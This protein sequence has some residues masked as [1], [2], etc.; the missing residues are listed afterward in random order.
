MRKILYLILLTLVST[1][2]IH[3]QETET[4]PQQQKEGVK[5]DAGDIFL[6]I[7]SGIDY[8]INA[9]RTS[10]D[11]NGFTF[12]KRNPHF[13]IGGYLGVM[14]TPKFRPRL[15]MKY[16]RTSYEQNWDQSQYPDF[17]K[18]TVKLGNLDLN[19]HF[20]YL[21]YNTEKW[22]VFIS[23]ALKCEFMSGE[24]YNTTKSNGDDDSNDKFKTLEERYP[25]SIAGG[26]LS[27]IFK[28]DINK[29][30]GLTFTPDYTYFFRK[31]QRVNSGAYQRLSFNVGLEFR[32]H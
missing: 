31:Y 15:E 26:A 4:T 29:K 12:D 2:V 28:Y 7:S 19:L 16:V 22:H 8:D 14:V 23:P 10:T 13:N 32:F 21:V 18:T 25:K 27:A 1:S 24:D 5:Y 17:I 3:A 6:G 11:E 30:V 9:Y 20:D